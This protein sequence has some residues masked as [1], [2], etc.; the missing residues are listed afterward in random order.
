M[1][2]QLGFCATLAIS[3]VTHFTSRAVASEARKAPKPNVVIIFCDD[4]GYGDLGCY[5]HPTIRTPEIDTL[6]SG[7]MRFTQFYSPAPACTP[8]RAALLTGRLPRRTG[9]VHVLFPKSTGGL[10][11]A[12]VTL[13]EA[14]R[15][16]G[17]ATACIGKWHLGHLPE[18]LPTRHGFDSY[19]G[20]PYSNDMKPTPLVRD[21]RVVEEPADQK[22]LTPRYTDEAVK[23]I[24]AHQRG[25]FFLYVAHNFPH[26]P[27]SASPQGQGRSARGL[28]GDVVEDIDRS[29]GR[30]MTT[31]RRL[32]LDEKTLVIF[33]SD[34]GPWL[35]YKQNG[36]SAGLLREGKATTWEGGVRVPCVMWWPGHIQPGSVSQQLASTLDVFPTIMALAAGNESGDRA[37]DG[38][39]LS[40]V[41]SGKG[42]SPRSMMFFYCDS[43][44][45][46]VRKGPW[47]LHLKIRPAAR[48]AIID[49]SATPLLFQL[50]HDPSEQY[51]LAA[52]QPAIVA[53]LRAQAERHLREVIP[54]PVQK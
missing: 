28:Y 43:E 14:L 25:P 18:F 27:L 29:T 11:S 31:L 6:A 1:L 23:F 37:L 39:D 7:G 45:M 32:G 53:D 8:S 54:A 51:D 49:R 24:T 34:N 3:A 22:T 21:T 30:I 4:L 42:P 41:L 16:R 52:E 26:V 50:D 40:A 47:K 13:A 38:Y 48:Q 35:P 10:P 46:A 2:R 15:E 9:L 19:F 17:Y 12:E 44:L 33:S 20:I 36:G 5:G